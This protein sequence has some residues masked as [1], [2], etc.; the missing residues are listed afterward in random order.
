MG[1]APGARQILQI[2]SIPDENDPIPAAPRPLKT[3]IDEIAANLVG[4][5]SVVIIATERD[6]TRSHRHLSCS[7]NMYAA[8]ASVRATA[9]AFEQLH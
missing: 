9:K 3:T 4:A 5:D 1:W 6:G 7:G 8:E 2:M